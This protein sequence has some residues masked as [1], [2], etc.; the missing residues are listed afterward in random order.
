M[1][2]CFARAPTSGFAYQPRAFSKTWSTTRL[3][4][5]QEARRHRCR[6]RGLRRLRPDASRCAR[7]SSRTSSATATSRS[8]SRS[9][10]ASGA[11]TPAPP[12]SPT[13]AIAQTVQAAY[14]IARFTAEDP[15]AGLPDEADIASAEAAPDLDLFHPWDVDAAS[16]RPSSRCEC[17][18]AAL[19]DRQAHHQQRRRRRLGAAEPL[20]QRATRAASAA[21]MPARAIRSRWR[22]S[23][24]RATTCSATPGTARCAS[25]DELAAPEAVGPLCRRARAVAPEVAQDHDRRMPGAVRVAAGRR[26]A[27]RPSCRR[28]AAARCTARAPSC[29]TRWASRCCP[30]H[31]DVAE[32]PHVPRGKGSAPFDDEGVRTQRAQGGRRAASSQGYFLCTYSARKLGMKTTGNAGGSHNLTL[33]LAPHAAGRRPRRDARQARHAACS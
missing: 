10:S 19:V 23:P 2:T 8:A 32:D 31:I 25:A 1:T 33:T 12:T 29:S 17:E 30:T 14:D 13:A 18:A 5:R 20:L 3:A 7:A 4:H 9:T 27:R 11:A 24:A 15:V 16:R 28:R 22:R 21:A 6:R 26:P